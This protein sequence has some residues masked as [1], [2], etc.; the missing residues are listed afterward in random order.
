MNVQQ[1]S[2]AG[3]AVALLVVSA[4]VTIPFGPVPFTL[5]TLA[6]AI[7][8]AALDRATASAA[9]AVYL[10]LGC[11]GLPVFS[12]FSGGISSLVGMTGGFLWGFFIGTVAA[13]TLE[14]ALEHRLP[15][16]ARALVGN[17][18]ML[19]ISYACG[20]LQLMVVGSM[21]IVP[22][23]LAAVVPFIVPDAVKLAVGTSIGCSVSR[24]LGH[25]VQH[26]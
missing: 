16:F 5:Q 11:I 1:L 13:T 3:V 17:V 15:L 20:T 14:R 26:G 2:R 18:A 10:L 12:G 22:A 4:W 21:G 9:V 24:A 6:L 7:L 23:L 19:L 8:P 25:V